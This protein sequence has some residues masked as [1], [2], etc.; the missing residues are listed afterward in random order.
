MGRGSV[1]GDAILTSKAIGGVSFT[2]SVDTGRHVAATCA[3]RLAK[4]QLEM[5]GKNP[6]VVLDD[7]D[8]GVAVG[9]A[10]N[11]AFF[12]TG[13]RCPAASRLILTAG[14]PHPLVAAVVR[15]E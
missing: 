12:S 14:L 5:G 13:Q 7:A 2:G 6:M 1:V 11:G 9:A 4:V 10:V 8:L 3:G 15:P